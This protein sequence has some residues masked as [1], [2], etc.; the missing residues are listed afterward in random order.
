MR[1]DPKML[2]TKVGRVIP[3]FEGLLTLSTT[4]KFKAAAVIPAEI[5]ACQN[6][7]NRLL[8]SYQLLN[9]V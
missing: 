2:N 3:Y 9:Y 7:E 4:T 8:F 5:T 6:L 1:F